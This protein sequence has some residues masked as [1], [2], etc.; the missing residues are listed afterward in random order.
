MVALTSNALGKGL[1]V[2]FHDIV[3]QEHALERGSTS[4]AIAYIGITSDA[5]NMGDAGLT[6]LSQLQS[7]TVQR[8]Q[9]DAERP[10]R[11]EIKGVCT[12]CTDSLCLSFILLPVQSERSCVVTFVYE[13]DLAA[14]SVAEY[15]EKAVVDTIFICRM[16]SS[17]S[18]GFT[19]KRL[20][21]T[22]LYC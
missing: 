17:T 3:Y 2:R 22:T 20:V 9:P 6:R 5:D 12:F 10:N 19:G 21:L 4:R 1:D 15:K 7:C 18:I 11:R 16:A 8:N 13:I 14:F